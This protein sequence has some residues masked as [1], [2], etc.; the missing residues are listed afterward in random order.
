VDEQYRLPQLNAV[1]FPS[2]VDDAAVRKT[3]LA[4]YDLEIGSGLGALAGKVWRIGMM[5][6]ASNQK[7]VF[8]CLSALASVLNLQGHTCD[9]NAAIGAVNKLYSEKA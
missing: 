7:N 8:F 6:F 2:S 4:K 1:S 3:L 5:G 9:V